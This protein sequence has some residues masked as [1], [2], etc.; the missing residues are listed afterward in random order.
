MW[1]GSWCISPISAHCK[2]EHQTLWT[3]GL[4]FKLRVNRSQNFIVDWWFEVLLCNV[5]AHTYNHD[6][7]WLT[8]QSEYVPRIQMYFKYIDIYGA[9]GECLK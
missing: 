4:V 9:I 1:S 3:P 2:V 6:T 5:V 8:Q 7:T